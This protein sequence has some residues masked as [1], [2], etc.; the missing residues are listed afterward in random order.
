MTL[1]L[2]VALAGTLV[3]ALLQGDKHFYN[4]SGGYWWLGGTFTVNGHFS[5]LNFDPSR[6]YV[7][8]LIN[9]FLDV[10]AKDL[11]W[12]SSSLVKTLNAFTFALVGAVLGPALIA[13]VWPTQPSWG[14]QRRLALTALLAVFWCGYLDFP[15]TDFPGLAMALLALVAVARVDSRSWMLV[16]GIAL[17]TAIN[18][19][20]AYLPLVPFFALLVGWSWYE[21]RN[22][23]HAS[24]LQRAVCVGLLVAGFTT[25][26]LPQAI[27]THRGYG[28]W[29][30]VP[31]TPGALVYLDGGLP[32]QSTNTYIL[33]RPHRE[34]VSLS[35]SYLYPA[36][37]R[38][39]EEQKG[40]SVTSVS[41]YL[42]LFLSHPLVMGGL[43]A[44]HVVNGL[45]P[46]YS[47]PYIEN[48]HTGARQWRRVAAFLLVFLALARVL[49][50]AARRMLGPG[51]LRY[52]VALLACC[53]TTLPTGGEM[54]YLLPVYLVV[55]CL[56]LTPGWPNPIAAADRAGW[57]RLQT[58]AALAVAL[59]AFTSVVWYI[60]NDAIS[61]LVIV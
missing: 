54:R 22:A 12:T 42:G 52:I 48:L 30:F 14:V 15:L 28:K 36:G 27:V 39:R 5:L 10:A 17:A 23:P 55:Y 3:V 40:G 51:R 8:P 49:W 37:R 19:R 11:A 24:T 60:T 38:L 59:A 26:S 9:H 45:D 7:L 21:Q 58:P 16:A 4:D 18:M 41:Q 13:T 31:V 1:A 34:A 61:H 47:T 2:G 33:S 25:V 56:A 57:R 29:S 6:G 46:L 32:L 43:F 50:P 44:S 20:P 35:M 53:L